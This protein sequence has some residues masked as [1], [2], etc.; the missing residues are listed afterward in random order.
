MLVT[1]ATDRGLADAAGLLG[2][3]AMA[4][5]SSAESPDDIAALADLTADR[6][7]GVDLLFLNAGT[8]ANATFTEVDPGDYDRIFAINTRGPFFTAQRFVPLMPAGSSIVLITS[9]ADVKGITGRPPAS[10]HRRAK[11]PDHKFGPG[12][13]C[14]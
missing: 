1:G 4:V 8:T 5:R 2:P 7:G 12:W 11:S 10:C 3:E 9:V 13:T 14:L 6:L